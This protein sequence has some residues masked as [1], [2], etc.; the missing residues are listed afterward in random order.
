L[1]AKGVQNPSFDRIKERAMELLPE[2]RRDKVISK[3]LSDLQNVAEQAAI[4]EFYQKN[5]MRVPQ[6]IIGA[7]DKYSLFVEALDRGINPWAR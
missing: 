1:A 5:K 4:E 3:T 7:K 2:E 6:D